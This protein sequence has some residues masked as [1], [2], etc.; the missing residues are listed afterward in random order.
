MSAR[1]TLQYRVFI[2]APLPIH[3]LPPAAGTQPQWSPL[4]H[5]LV[6]GPTE[7][8]LVDP[9]LT[10]AQA[11]SLADWVEAFGKRLAHIYITHWH[12]DHWLSTGELARRFPGVTVH[13]SAATVDRMVKNTPDGVPAGTWAQWF[14]GQLPA[15]P[16]PVLARP[17]PAGGFTVD[18][19]TLVA[20][21]AGHSDTDDTTV[22]HAPSIGLVAAGDVVYN[23]VHQYLAETTGGGMEAWHRALDV[24]ESLRAVN[25]VAG[26]K[27]P[28]RDDSPTNIGNTHAYLDHAANLLATQPTRAEFYAGMVKLYPERINPYTV[29]LSA[30]RLL[31][32]R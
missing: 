30:S 17:V 11:R 8:A 9:P 5:T 22:L 12:A 31:N 25:V 6:F 15:N 4:S 10:L 3:A 29:W 1:S 18:G 13:A 27:D 26:H 19:H 24:V 20:V 16:I 14:P 23:N 21:D 32:D 7:A 28:A 2:S